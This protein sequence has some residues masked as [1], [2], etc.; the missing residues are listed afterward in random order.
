MRPDAC[1]TGMLFFAFQE[2][3]VGEDIF[4]D[5]QPDGGDIGGGI[6]C[7][8]LQYKEVGMAV[9]LDPTDDPTDRVAIGIFSP[10]CFVAEF[11][12][13]II[14]HQHH[15]PHHLIATALEGKLIEIEFFHQSQLFIRGYFNAAIE[16]EAIHLVND[17]PFIPARITQCIEPLLHAILS[18]TPGQ[19][20]E[21]GNR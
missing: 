9:F 6:G 11:V 21:I 18:Y 4:Q 20:L 14:F 15:F 19:F 1:Q 8:K 3:K 2:A 17:S 10:T 5:L 7:S 13:G 16:P 12:I